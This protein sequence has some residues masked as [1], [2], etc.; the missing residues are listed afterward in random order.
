MSAFERGGV[1]VLVVGGGSAGC[2]VAAR[3]SESGTR[4]VGLLEAGPDYGPFDAGRWPAELLDANVD[5]T[6][7]HDWGFEGGLS[8]SRARVI[9]GCS[10]HNGCGLVWPTPA[11]ID[12]WAGAGA[13]GWTYDA[14][15]PFLRGAATTMRARPSKIDQLEPVRRAFL[16]AARWVGTRFLDDLDAPDATDGVGLMRM[17]AVG[18]TR[19]NAAVAYLDPVRHRPNFR[20]LDRTLVDRVLVMGG[21]AVG[22]RVIRDGRTQDLR[23]DRVIL[24]AGAFATPAILQ[25]SG[26][27]AAAELQALGITPIVD[28]PGVGRSMANHPYVA[29]RFNPTLAR[30]ASASADAA[31]EVGQVQ[32]RHRVPGRPAV[33]W[34]LMLGAW[35]APAVDGSGRPVGPPEAGILA[36][37]SKPR[38]VGRVAIRSSD[39]EALPA[40]EHGFLTDPDGH[41]R[42]LLVHGARLARSIARTP[43]FAAVVDREREPGPA[44][45]DA[46]LPAWVA[47]T[48]TGDYHPCGTARMGDPAN[49]ATVVNSDGEVVGVERLSVVDASLFPTIPSTNI[50]LTVL[51][52][53]ERLAER[54]AARRR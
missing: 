35:C 43:L 17:N 22:A 51:A 36:E 45:S 8:S 9:G 10:S 24:A 52:V 25:R 1:D 30:L 38:S 18:A 3:L 2:V 14:L 31:R 44:G 47:R 15:A 29:L 53:A 19:W 23:A 42:D 54:I 34:D 32:L 40:I 41:D 11:D 46:E 5:A 28:L 7:S 37:V 49:P 50:H 39:P 12:E 27:G 4:A 21:R 16:D 6:G 33:G 26:I 48:V 13:A 20:I